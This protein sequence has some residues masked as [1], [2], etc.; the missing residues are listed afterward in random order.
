MDAS[1]AGIVVAAEDR[2]TAGQGALG[3]APRRIVLVARGL[4]SLGHD[5]FLCRRAAIEAARLGIPLEILGGPAPLPAAMAA[6]LGVRF[7]FR[8]TPGPADAAPDP[9]ADE[10]DRYEASAR[11]FAE[12]LVDAGLGLGR[13]DMVWL[14]SASLSAIDGLAGGLRRLRVQPFVAACLHHATP[15]DASYAPGTVPALLARLALRHI[16]R[17]LGERPALVT[18]TTEGLARRLAPLLGRAVPTL[19]L[20]HWYDPPPGE[21]TTPPPLPP[22]DGPLIGVLGRPRPDKGLPGLQAILAA[23]HAAVPKARLVV[24]DYGP[25]AAYLPVHDRLRAAGIVHGLPWPISDGAFLGLVGRLDLV[26]LPYR[27]RSFVD[28]VSGPFCF[29]AA[30]GV[31]VVATAGTWMA[32]EIAAGRAAGAVL[33]DLA[34]HTVARAVAGALADLA[35]TK[36]RAGALAPTWRAN[37]GTRLI[38]ELLRRARLAP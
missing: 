6:D 18:A 32:G 5:R 28:R 17:A 19:P 23:V 12:D 21:D 36:A 7:I 3:P 29:A 25:D 34:P 24:Q 11:Q 26:L 8:R 13:E 31:P 37:D 10:Y 20:P 2:A 4:D 30:S 33:D 16:E 14:P 1:P 35:R 38:A 9:Y 27:A 15:P 22:G